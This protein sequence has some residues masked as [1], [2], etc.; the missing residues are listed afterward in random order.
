MPIWRVGKI[1]TSRIAVEEADT[2]GEACRKAG[3]EPEDCETADIT[4][5]VRILV[6]SG[7]LR[8]ITKK[9]PLS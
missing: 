8:V 4:G 1:G 9:P 5:T 7:D 3:W 2:R 6:A